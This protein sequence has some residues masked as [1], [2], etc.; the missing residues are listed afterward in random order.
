M[1]EGAQIVHP[2]GHQLTSQRAAQYP[3]L[4]EAGEEIGKDGDNL[5]AHIE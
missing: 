4:E 1:S 5:K 2:Y 3:V